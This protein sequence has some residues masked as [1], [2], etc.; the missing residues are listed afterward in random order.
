MTDPSIQAIL[1]DMDGVLVDTGDLH[2][3]TWA[4]TLALYGK[5]I[6]RAFFD[7]TFGMNNW[8][9]LEALFGEL[10]DRAWCERFISQKESAFC[11]LLRGNVTPIDGVL[12]ALQR[13]RRQGL[14][15]AVASSAPS[16]NIQIILEE[17][18]LTTFF[19]AVISAANWP[20]KPNPKVFLEAAKA[21]GLPPARCLVIEDAIPG[22]EAAHR[23]G[24][25]CIAIT[26]TNTPAQ[27]ADA[28]LVIHS[29][30]DLDNSPFLNPALHRED[31]VI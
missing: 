9:T 3:R 6:D 28:E 30:R 12:D 14:K 15:Q 2:Y 21:L 16:A 22:V 11:D 19:D 10:P 7:R 23:A 29:F 24:I 8:G 1:W 26:T 13:F 20:G 25:P 27:L 4:S 5:T 18:G 31:E 17:L